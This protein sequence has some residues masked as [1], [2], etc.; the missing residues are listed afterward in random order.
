MLYLACRSTTARSRRAEQARSARGETAA[1]DQ[2]CRTREVMRG[3][4]CYLPSSQRPDVSGRSRAMAHGQT[5]RECA[6]RL[7]DG[8]LCRA[9][10]LQRDRLLL[11]AV[12]ACT[13]LLGFQLLATLL[14]PPW[15]GPVPDWLLTAL[16]WAELA[17]ILSVSVWLGRARW[18]GAP[19]PALLSAALL[20]YAVARAL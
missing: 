15:L 18:L 4:A 9:A 17:V 11:G 2:P 13:L 5:E 16:A 10:S 3:T 12:A 20:W 7:K 6:V 8:V 19:S 14:H 1:L